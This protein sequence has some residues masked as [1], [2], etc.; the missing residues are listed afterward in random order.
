MQDAFRY[1]ERIEKLRSR[2]VDPLITTEPFSLA[3]WRAWRDSVEEEEYARYADA[4]EVALDT[5]PLCVDGGEAIVA[6]C[7]APLSDTEREEWNALRPIADARVARVGQDSHMAPDFDLLLSLGVVGILQKVTEGERSH[8]E[9]AA[10]YAACRRCLLAT[11]KYAAR[12][13]AHTRK[14]AA[15]LEG[16]EREDLLLAAQALERVP[17]YP[18][19]T[20]LE[21]VQAAHFLAHV[22]SMDPFRYFTT[23]Q[24]QLGRPDRY[25]LPYYHKDL[26]SGAITREKARFLIDCL[27]IQINH[28]VPHGLSSG[29]MVGGRDAQG[30]PTVND[31]TY[32]FME[33]VDDVRLVYPSVGLCYTSDMPPEVLECAC[34]ILSHGRSHPAI[35]NDDVIARGLSL[36][37]VPE[38]ETRDY[39][40][41]TCVE[42]TPIAASNVW[43]ASPY[44]NMPGILLET[45]GEEHPDFDSLLSAY[46]ARVDGVIQRNALEQSRWREERKRRGM[47][48][49]LSC[50][51]SDC[52]SRGLDI[53]AGGARYNWIMPSFVGMANAADSLWAVKG[54]VFDDGILSLGELRDAIASDFRG[55]EPL[56][57][58]LAEKYAKYGNDDDG[59]DSVFRLLSEHLVAECRKYT[60]PFDSHLVPSVFCWV[61]HERL[62]RETPATPDGRAAGFPLGDG[63]GPCQGRERK[64]PTASVLSSTK[65]D[66]APFIGGVAV[67]MKFSKRQFTS[68][69]LYNVIALTRTYMERGGFEMQIN[70]V[71]GEVLRAARRDPAS[72]RDLVVRIGGYSDYYVTLS[73]EMQEEVL[74]R[75]EHE[76]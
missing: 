18:A 41:S 39:I 46:L 53:E 55:R 75:T 50:F 10:F 70:V 71:D 15:T 73:P 64:G 45:L 27:A 6:K 37:G 16:E 48:P 32:L 67:N 65:W 26:A 54:A 68:S 1:R 42:I 24:F 40:H 35:F 7:A 30:I 28:R 14:V 22:L 51:V 74:L 52:L 8:P 19:E 47:K 66:H 31:L 3:F 34:R 9:S 43:V 2:A 56:R 33:A 13:A 44:S 12:Y 61:M 29:Y 21:A 5:V 76:V 58:L 60:V 62:G 25:L 17:L 23:L 11:V 36:W 59:V 57:R 4:Y 69:S 72:Y 38:G 20:F 49:L 63:S